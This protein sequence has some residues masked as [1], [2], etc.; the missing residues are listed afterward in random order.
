MIFPVTLPL[1]DNKITFAAYDKDI[2]SADDH[3]AEGTIDFSEQANE[4]FMYEQSAK[5]D[6][7]SF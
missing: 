1:K 7:K 3:I 5:V 4:A 6:S 2:V